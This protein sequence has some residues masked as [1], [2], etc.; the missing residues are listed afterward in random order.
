MAT[1][2][3]EPTWRM[4]EM[5]AEPE[6]LRSAV[7][8]ARV[9][10]IADGITRPKPS[11][12]TATQA[13]VYQVE[14]CSVVK[15]PIAS[16][17]AMTRYPAV[18]TARG[19]A[20]DLPAIPSEP[21]R[22]DCSRVPTTIPTTMPSTIGSSRRPLP[23]ELAPRTSWKYC[24][25]AKNRPNIANDRSVTRIVP[26]RNPTDWNSARSTSDC[27]PR[28]VIRRSTS[29]NR[30]SGTRPPAMVASAVALPQ[31][32]SPALMH[33]YVT[34]ISPA[35]EISTPSTSIDGRLAGRDSGSRKITATS[36]TTTTGT[37]IRKTE[38]H[39]KWSSR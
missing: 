2:I 30:A 5:R 25:S 6:P 29:T 24:G 37:L 31:P 23:S 35:L 8:E 1:P 32:F 36:A 17:T 39:Q 34:A 10:F 19:P 11:P 9:T 7:S 18:N 13:S 22:T 3:T 27:P 12:E 26:Q 21:P 16:A 38:P 14:L 15:A 4:A 33:P 28:A 20:A